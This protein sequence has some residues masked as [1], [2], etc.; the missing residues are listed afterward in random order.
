MNDLYLGLT[1]G[2]GSLIMI[3]LLIYFSIKQHHKSHLPK[4]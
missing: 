4:K 3:G 2:L 1:F